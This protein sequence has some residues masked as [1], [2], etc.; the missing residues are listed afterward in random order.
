MHRLELIGFTLPRAEGTLLLLRTEDGKRVV[1]I[2]IGSTE[3]IAIA[4]RLGGVEPARPMT[5]DLLSTFVAHMGAQVA[6]V[7]IT[8]LRDQA[9]HALI[10]LA[11]AAGEVGIDARP[12]DA[13]ALA[14]RTDAP[15]FASDQVVEEGSVEIPD[16]EDPDQ[17]LD[18]FRSFLDDVSPADFA[19]ETGSGPAADEDQPA[20]R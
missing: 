6:Q 20:P 19:D 3:A 10:T 8:E 7:E 17:V 11:T 13:I 18:E 5:H 1:P 9:F 16:D 4:T 15:I 14:V 12:S 2:G